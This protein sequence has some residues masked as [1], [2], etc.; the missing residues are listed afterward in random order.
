MYKYNIH[1]LEH[2]DDNDK[3]VILFSYICQEVKQLSSGCWAQS[4]LS[5]ITNTVFSSFFPY[6]LDLKMQ[7]ECQDISSGFRI[8][9]EGLHNFARKRIVG[10]ASLNPPPSPHQATENN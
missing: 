10:S 7:P 2:I 6:G 3:S 4:V 9:E 8:P 5:S 1:F